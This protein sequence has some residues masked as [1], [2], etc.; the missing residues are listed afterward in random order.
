MSVTQR[1]EIITGIPKENKPRHFLT[2]WRP[3]S[4][5]RERPF[6]LQGGGGA[7]GFFFGQHKS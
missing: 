2:N 4:L 6:N 7:M 1:E 5:L 3:I